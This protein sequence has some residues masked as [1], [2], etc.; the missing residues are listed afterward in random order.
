[1]NCW[2]IINQVLPMSRRALLHGPPGTG[3]THVGQ[4]LGV[5]E[6][7]PVYSIYITEY[8]PVSEPRGNFMPTVDDGGNRIYKWFDGPA[9]AAARHGGRL[10]INEIDKASDDCITFFLALLDDVEVARIDLPTGEVVRPHP[11]FSVVGTMNAKP[12]ALLEALRDRFPV[13]ILVDKVNPEA[14]K[15]LPEDLRRPAIESQ[16]KGTHS[17]RSWMA[18]A[19]L[20]EKVAVPVALQ[21]CF[22]EQAAEMAAMME[23]KA[24]AMTAV[25]KKRAAGLS[26]GEAAALC[27]SMGM[28]A[29]LPHD[30]SGTGAPISVIELVNR[31]GPAATGRHIFA[32]R[33]S[34]VI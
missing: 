26:D 24:R 34:G 16:E 13:T 19:D 32:L 20:R 7:Q 6:N 31:I 28:G 3:K 5:G 1:M 29:L 11:N 27:T 30:T 17:I 9:L 22:G 21:A 23:I 15:R 12:I 25:S 33:D 10:V 4:R 18:Y 8:T 14:V 2:D